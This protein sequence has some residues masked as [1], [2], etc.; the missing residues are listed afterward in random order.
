MHR[1]MEADY[2]VQTLLSKRYS[3]VLTH[4]YRDDLLWAATPKNAYGTTRSRRP[5]SFLEVC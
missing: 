3:L 2:V 1:P 4:P 5:F